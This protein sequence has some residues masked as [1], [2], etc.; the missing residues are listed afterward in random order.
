M[1]LQAA[2]LE[3][4]AFLVCTVHAL[5]TQQEEVMGLCLSEVGAGR[6]AHIHSV[7]IL[8]RSDT[9]K[10]QVEISL[11]QLSAASTE[12]ERL[13]ELTGQPT[14]VVSWYHSHFPS[15]DVWK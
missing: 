13:A 5:S 12:A 9:R 8:L 4:D 6:I 15:S 1:A 7:I 10:D 3:A 11:E 2:H 14:R